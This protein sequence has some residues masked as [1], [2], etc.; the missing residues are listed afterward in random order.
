MSMSQVWYV[1]HIAIAAGGT[2]NGVDLGWCTS[3]GLALILYP[4]LRYLELR[5]CKVGSSVTETPSMAH[6][7]EHFQ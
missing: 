7:V 5:W 2:P 4:P 1:G 6:T 3:F